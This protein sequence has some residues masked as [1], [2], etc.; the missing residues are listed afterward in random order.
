MI[1]VGKDAA[2][3]CCVAVGGSG[4]WGCASPHQA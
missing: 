1:S 2:G 3:R 4:P